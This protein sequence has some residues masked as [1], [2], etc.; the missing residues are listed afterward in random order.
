MLRDLANPLHARIFHR[1]SRV[2]TLGH[3]LLDQDL[4]ALVKQR[5][6]LLLNGNRFVNL[7]GFCIQKI[8]DGGLFGL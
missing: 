7:G 3:S 8:G 5:D 2:E 1:H 4:L 6:L